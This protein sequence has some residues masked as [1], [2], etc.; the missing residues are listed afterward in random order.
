[1][2]GAGM[3]NNCS[4]WKQICDSIHRS[5][6]QYEQNI[7]EKHWVTCYEQ[8]QYQSQLF[9][10][11]VVKVS[12]MKKCLNILYFKHYTIVVHLNINTYLMALT[13]YSHCA[14]FLACRNIYLSINALETTSVTHQRQSV[15]QVDE[16]RHCTSKIGFFIDAYCFF[17]SFDP[18][19]R[20]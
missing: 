18:S 1:M 17:M 10:T 11:G 15:I 19:K 2:T 14:S 12:A 16:C 20:Q 3:F 9:Y 5:C 7:C 4:S 8:C 13:Q 6:M